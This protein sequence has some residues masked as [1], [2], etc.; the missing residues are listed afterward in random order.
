M[1]DNPAVEEFPITVF[2]GHPVEIVLTKTRLDNQIRRLQ[3]DLH[4]R[5]YNTAYRTLRQALA[6]AGCVPIFGGPRCTRAR[7]RSRFPAVPWSH[8]V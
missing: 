8:A 4:E 2:A 6:W 3:R 5:D 1:H 7:F